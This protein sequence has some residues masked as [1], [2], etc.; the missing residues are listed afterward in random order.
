[1]GIYLNKEAKSGFSSQNRAS[2]GRSGIWAA[3]LGPQGGNQS[4]CNTVALGATGFD[5]DLL[6]SQLRGGGYLLLSTYGG[7]DGLL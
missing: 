5:S 6:E 4:T 3:S 7:G 1:M 2:C